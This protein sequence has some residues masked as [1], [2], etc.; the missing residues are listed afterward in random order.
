M[1]VSEKS[2]KDELLEEGADVFV[3]M[4]SRQGVEYLFMNPGTDTVPIQESLA[5]FQV[6]GK[7]A[8]K[9]ILCLHEFVAMSA[10]H[11]YFMVSGKPQ[12]VL[13][14]VGVGTQQ[15][16]GALHN[17]HRS[18]AAVILCA[19]ATPYLLS[20][21]NH[22]GGRTTHV[23]WLQDQFDQAGAV[24]DYVKWSYEMK[25]TDHIQEV[26]PRAFQVAMSEP[27]GPVY[28]MLPK[29]VLMQGNSRKVEAISKYPPVLSPEADSSALSELAQWLVKAE[30]PLIITGSSG[31]NINAVPPL[32][33]LAET[34][35]IPVVD[36]RQ[37]MN[38]PSHHPCWQGSDPAPYI[39]RA[40]VVLI[41]DEDVPYIP[42]FHCPSPGAKIAYLDIDP[43]KKDIPLWFFN[44][45]MMLH[46]DSAKSL[47]TLLRMVRELVNK[48]D[49]AKYEKRLE[50]LRLEHDA[51]IAGWTRIAFEKSN[52]KPIDKYWLA[53]CIN[54]VVDGETIVC[55]ETVTSND[56]ISKLVHTH[57][58][59]TY[60]TNGGSCLGWGLGAS[61]GAKL[62]APDKTVIN[63]MGDGAFLFGLP[64][65]SLWGAR[66]HQAPFLSI[67]FNN[68]VYQAPKSNLQ[69]DYKE[70]YAQKHNLWLGLDIDPPPDYALMAQSCGAYGE[71]VEEPSAI[72]EALERALAEVRGGRAAVL[73][74]VLK[75]PQ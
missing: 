32:V 47:S 75:K 54:E 41:V 45:D 56:S 20:G 50:K 28:L 61:L 21:I 67:V 53:H 63:L 44:A 11:G 68:R 73:D 15:L 5:K 9:V 27:Y 31:R 69:R 52:Q 38:Y 36:S 42:S 4:L 71:R 51:R 17:A 43:V 2:R 70:G 74:V 65:A 10:A 40:D 57:Q 58:C 46:G 62:A 33:Q 60:F 13:V 30:Q 18:H 35:A 29:E 64:I 25:C 16:G 1:A 3:E 48:K 72:M 7:P 23:H 22:R 39:A 26:V 8:P 6:L 59:G 34:L 14:H 66:Q 37:R 12:A 19:G 49:R 55:N 24:R